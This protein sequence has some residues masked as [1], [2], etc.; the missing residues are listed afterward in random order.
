MLTL[1]HPAIV[2]HVASLPC[3]LHPVPYPNDE[4]TI[5]LIKCPKEMILAAK[6][7]HELRIYLRTLDAD[8][9]ITHGLVTAFFDDPDE[10]L[11]IRSPLVDDEMA[12][13]LFALLS[14]K[15]FK[16]YFF[17][18]H[19]RELL[20]YRVRNLGVDKFISILKE[21]RLA[22]PTYVPSSKIDDQ[23]M[24]W[25]STR[26]S[27]DDAKALVIEFMEPLFPADLCILDGRPADNSHHGGNAPMVTMLERKDPGIFFELDIVKCLHRVFASEQIFLNP[28]RTDNGKEF[29]DVMVVTSGNILLIQAKDSPNTEDTLRRPIDRKIDTVYRHL[30]KAT[31]QMTGAISR[32]RTGKFLDVVC[33][34]TR[35]KI[36]LDS[37]KITALIV[38]RELFTTEYRTYS[39]FAFE[40][41]E[42]TGVHTF[43]QDYWEFG[44]L[45]YYRR[46]EKSFFATLDH[47]RAFALM[48]GEFPRSRFWI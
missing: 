26:N 35:H 44:E 38:V 11:T 34:G 32:T 22:R 27:E 48:Q 40:L 10:P 16:I 41:S 1:T 39:R 29:V 8:N 6:V 30:K 2:G 14:S 4:G 43:I 13:G 42:D 24:N 17:D 46:T 47:I 19:N 20:G 9:V 37:R 28:F 5:L 25:F 45:T 15:N 18:E 23:L 31:R 3:G 33:G 7:C 21:I 36:M 12:E